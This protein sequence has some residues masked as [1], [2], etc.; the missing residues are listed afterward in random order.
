MSLNSLSIKIVIDC[1]GPCLQHLCLEIAFH[2]FIEVSKQLHS[3]VQTTSKVHKEWNKT[4]TGIKKLGILTALLTRKQWQQ[5][6]PNFYFI[7][8]NL[9]HD[10]QKLVLGNLKTGLLYL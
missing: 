10:L 9:S 1:N 3:K 7:E 8:N 5:H 6:F 4:K 2:H